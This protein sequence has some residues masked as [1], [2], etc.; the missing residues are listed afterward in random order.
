[1]SE[2]SPSDIGAN[3]GAWAMYAVSQRNVRVH[4]FEPHPLI[5]EVLAANIRFLGLE[6]KVTP[7]P[8]AFSNKSGHGELNV[9]QS[10]H[11]FVPSLVPVTQGRG[12]SHSLPISLT[13][14]DSYVAVNHISDLKFIKIDTVRASSLPACP[15]CARHCRLKH[16]LR[17]EN[18]G[19]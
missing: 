16:A 9:V 17:K 2:V 19:N 3:V 12:D 6:T 7:S 1:M 18:V 8:L 14:V 11:W 15:I 13:T 5:F 4:T 10:K